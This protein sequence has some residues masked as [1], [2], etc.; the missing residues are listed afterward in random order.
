MK[1]DGVAS[2]NGIPI[3]KFLDR[4][5]YDHLAEVVPLQL[6]L[7]LE[8]R[9]QRR[10]PIF[11]EAAL[12]RECTATLWGPLPK[13]GWFSDLYEMPDAVARSRGAVPDMQSAFMV[14]VTSQLRA[15]SA[16]SNWLRPSEGLTYK[17]LATDLRGSVVGDMKLPMK[18]FYVELPP[19]LFFLE[20]PKTGYHEVRA[21]TVVEGSLTEKTVATAKLRGDPTAGE[22]RVGPRLV[23]EAYGEPNDNSENPFDDAWMFKSYEIG[24]PAMDLDAVVERST[25]HHK[26]YERQLNRG[27]LGDVKLDG[28]EMRDMLLKFILNLCVYLG[29]QGATI[30][31]IHAEEIGKL[32]AG[33]KRKNL[34]KNVQER[35]HRLENDRVFAVGTEI[36]VSSEFKEIVRSGKEGHPLTYR[37]LVR[38]HYRNQAHGPQRALRVRKWI[39]PHI[40]GAS[41]PTAVVGHTYTM[42]K[43]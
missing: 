33:K 37:T 39:E 38:G 15:T 22:V 9:F 7:A 31:H 13:T 4:E 20:D 29:S 16:T 14:W 18:A 34:R 42:G 21:L 27:R 2:L 28:F 19:K 11:R 35:V 8:K 26:E 12:F 32:T 23:I 3:E 10:E 17:L 1:E 30:R 43:R 36:E 40:R 24:D 5:M 41:L 6:M 25:A